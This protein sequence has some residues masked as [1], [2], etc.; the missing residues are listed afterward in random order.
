MNYE[1]SP[2]SGLAL[3]GSDDLSLA[4][5]EAGGGTGKGRDGPPRCNDERTFDKHAIAE[6]ESRLESLTIKDQDDVCCLGNVVEGEEII[7]GK[8]SIMSPFALV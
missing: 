8:H 6:D 1:K 5:K 4:L 2:T 7:Q 3:V